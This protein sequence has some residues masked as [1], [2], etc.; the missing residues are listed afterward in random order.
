MKHE[1][2]RKRLEERIEKNLWLVVVVPIVGVV[3]GATSL[4]IEQIRVRSLENAIAETA[5]QNLN[6]AAGHLYNALYEFDKEGKVILDESGKEKKKLEL[7]LKD[8]N[9]LHR[10]LGRVNAVRQALIDSNA[11]LKSMAEREK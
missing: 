11:R 7:G 4:A 3:F 8:I 1:S 2:W 6:E 10:S 5:W 9:D